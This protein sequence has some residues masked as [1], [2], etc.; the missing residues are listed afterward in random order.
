MSWASFFNLSYQVHGKQEV[1]KMSSITL[2]RVGLLIVYR[3]SGPNPRLHELKLPSME[4]HFLSAEKFFEPL[5][6]GNLRGHDFKVRQPRFH[7]VRRKAAF[8]VR[9][10]GPWNRL[11]HT[12]SKLRQC[13]VSRTAWMPTGAPLDLALVNPTPRIVLM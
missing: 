7:L 2:K 8:A 10:A 6:A 4:R 5:A 9:S 1:P 12:S 3:T 11:P 13:P